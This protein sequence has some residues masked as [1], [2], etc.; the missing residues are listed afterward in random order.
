ML[1]D[2]PVAALGRLARTRGRRLLAGGLV[3]VGV[4]GSSGKTSTKDL[5]AAVLEPLG[6]TVAPRRLVQ[7]RGRR[8]ADGAAAPTPATRHLVVEM[9]ARGV[10]HIAELCRITPPQIGVVLNVGAAHAGEF[11]SPEATARAKSELVA[12]LPDAA[13]GG[14]AVLNADDPLVAAMA[15]RDVGARGA[16]RPRRRTPTYGPSDVRLDG[17]G[18]PTFLLRAGDREPAE[19]TLPLHGAHHVSNALAAAAVA[20]EL[21]ATPAGLAAA[22]G[23]RGAAQPVADGGRRARRRGHRRQ[24]RVQRE[25][26]LGARRAGRAGGDG[27]RAADLGGARR[28]ARARRGVHRRARAGG[29]TGAQVGRRPPGRRGR[30]RPGDAHRCARRG[31]SRRRGEQ[32]WWPTCAAALELLPPSCSRATSCWSRRPAAAA[33]SRSREGL[34]GEAGPMRQV[35]LAASFGLIVTLFGTPVAIRLLVRQR[36]RPADPR[37][38]PDVPPHQARHADDGRRRHHLRRPA[39]LLRART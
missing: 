22:L 2:D 37:R 3:V 8:A 28:D 31:R 30:R 6:P 19:V 32:W 18:R 17:A 27:G 25:P 21:G 16:V 1:V 4:T 34:L 23:D 9:G 10:G 33:W 15:E 12:A 13:A 11:G 20:L 39:R 35:L 14:V 36:L 5:L 38:R 7:H 26:R 29:Q 24:R